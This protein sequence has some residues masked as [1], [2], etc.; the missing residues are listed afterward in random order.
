[1]YYTY[2][3]Q[4]VKL[5]ERLVQSISLPCA[6]DFKNECLYRTFGL[7][8]TEN[9]TCEDAKILRWTSLNL[10]AGFE[11]VKCSMTPARRSIEIEA[12]K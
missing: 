3:S 10:D 7:Y 12:T 8:F 6:I 4:H 5:P 2:F 11:L 9:E 1:M